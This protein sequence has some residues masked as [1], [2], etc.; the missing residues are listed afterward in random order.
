MVMKIGFIGTGGIARVH[1]SYLAEKEG[2]ELTAFCDTD[3]S[4]AKAAAEQHGAKAYT[5]HKQMLDAQSLDAVFVCTPPFAHGEIEL[6]CIAAGAHLFVEKP[7]ALDMATARQIDAGLKQRNL[8]GSVGHHWR[9]QGSTDLA[10]EL[11]GDEEIAFI[12]G[13]WIGGM[14]GVY[15]WRQMKLSGGQ[16]V[17]QCTHITDLA[18]S[19]CGEVGTVVATGA[20]TIMH[21]RV[22]KYDVYDTQLACVQFESGIVGSLDTSNVVSSGGQAYLKIFTPESAFQ[23]QG[24]LIVSRRGQETRYDAGGMGWRSPYHR[25]DDVFIEAIQTGDRSKIRSDYSDAL[26]TLAVTLAIN[27]ACE[28]GKPVKVDQM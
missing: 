5:E 24:G 28:T 1:R 4:R 13:Y 21:K 11:L 8:I 6:D 18:R 10:R 23:V 19:F 20:K 12:L 9:Y 2:V 15:W 27:K 14:P 26:K 16:A 22:E 7:L 17:E 25:E 3:E